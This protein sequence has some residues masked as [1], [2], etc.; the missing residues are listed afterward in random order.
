MSKT[1]AEGWGSLG[2]E[3]GAE[4]LRH[5]RVTGCSAGCPMHKEIS[6]HKW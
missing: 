6:T 3:G 2:V 5:F 4:G 1:G